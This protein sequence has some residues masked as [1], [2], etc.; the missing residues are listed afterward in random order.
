MRFRTGTG[1]LILLCAACVAMRPLGVGAAPASG[2]PQKL[3]PGPW[4]HIQYVEVV[5]D[6]PEEAFPDASADSE[7]LRWM[8][9]ADGWRDIEAQLSA[10]GLTRAEIDRLRA[11]AAP[12]AG[13][14]WSVRPPDELLLAMAPD[15]RTRLYALLGRTPE[16]KPYHSPFRFPG[17]ATAD[18]WFETLRP[19]PDL[20]DLLQRLTYARGDMLLF[21]DAPLALARAPT[22]E[23]RREILQAL[24]RTPALLARI[25][26]RADDP[27]DK[28]TEYWARGGRADDVRPLLEA[29]QRS[30]PQWSPSVQNL[31]PPF[32]RSRL[33]TFDTEPGAPFRDCHWTSVNFFSTQPTEPPVDP[34]ALKR[35]ILQDY[36]RIPAADQ[37]GDILLFRDA[38]QQVIHSCVHIA[39]QIVFTKNGGD[40]TQA[41]VLMLLDDVRKFYEIN[42]PL[43]VIAIRQ[44]D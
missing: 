22:P 9:S 43:D 25:R 4:G 44:R 3:A 8:F 32:A 15:T 42:G 36:R 12:R 11:Q 10:M 20:H 35:I 41:W 23:L 29:V 34:E 33:N 30:A 17:P 28:L 24:Y 38:Q 18:E 6:A 27:V 13:G 21:S 5:L 16:N 37:L 31:L 26:V 40:S 7:D 2:S 1:L 39:D 19:H 14:G